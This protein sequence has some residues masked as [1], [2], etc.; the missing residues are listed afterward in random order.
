M[1]DAE[2]LWQALN[3]LP[4]IAEVIERR[5]WEPLGFETFTDAWRAQGL[6]DVTLPVET[7]PYVVYQML[8]ERVPTDEIALL[9]KG[10]GPQ[11][12]ESLKRQK[13]NGVP[14]SAASSRYTGNNR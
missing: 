12:V 6:A 2:R 7:R 9:V 5:A 13:S 8:G 3:P 11:T 14:P 10:V 4:V 1:G